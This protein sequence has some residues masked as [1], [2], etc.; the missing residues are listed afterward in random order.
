MMQPFL[1]FCIKRMEQL[2]STT[3][4]WLIVKIKVSNWDGV[5]R[6]FSGFFHF[7]LEC[8]GERNWHSSCIDRYIGNISIA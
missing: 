5:I 1:D 3:R 8:G 6:I 2:V 4:I 7:Q